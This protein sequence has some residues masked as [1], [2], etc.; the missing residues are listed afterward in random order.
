MRNV[1]LLSTVGFSFL[2][3]AL[4]ALGAFASLLTLTA[5]GFFVFISVVGIIL[6]DNPLETLL[7]SQAQAG[8]SAAQWH[9]L[10]GK[11]F[12][13]SLITSPF[14]HGL[15]I[16]FGIAALMAAVAAIFSVLRGKK[17]V[18]EDI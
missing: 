16:V 11:S 18:H 12:F 8:V 15:F 10:T 5:F 6:K 3:E 2:A 4:G 7:G 17:F 1:T 13:P 14:H 9:V